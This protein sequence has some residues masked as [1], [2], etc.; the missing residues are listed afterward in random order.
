MPPL[1][2]A[3]EFVADRTREMANHLVRELDQVEA[4]RRVFWGP[5]RPTDYSRYLLQR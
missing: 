3:E 2:G 1:S 4:E 5:H